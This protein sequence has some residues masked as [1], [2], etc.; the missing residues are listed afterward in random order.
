MYLE[1]QHW[2]SL[3]NIL[4]LY[5]GPSVLQFGALASALRPT[6]KKFKFDFDT[7]PFLQYFDKQ[8]S[9]HAETKITCLNLLFLFSKKCSSNKFVFNSS[10]SNAS[11]QNLKPLYIALII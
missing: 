7:Y 2:G 8:K 10:N 11:N 1:A 9:F 6:A 4:S 5:F 3:S